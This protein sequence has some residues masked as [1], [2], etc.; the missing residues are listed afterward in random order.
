MYVKRNTRRTC[1]QPQ[2]LPI[3]R[4]ATIRAAIAAQA[5]ESHVEVPVSSPIY[6]AYVNIGTKKERRR[7]QIRRLDLMQTALAFSYLTH[8]E[9]VSD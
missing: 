9:S 8:G 1:A 3:A 4:P 7:E 2:P 5:R 6:V